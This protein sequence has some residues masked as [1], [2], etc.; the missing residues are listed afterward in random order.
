MVSRVLA[1]SRV[2]AINTP[3]LPQCRE[4]RPEK[5]VI[6]QATPGTNRAGNIA[7][8]YRL[9]PGGYEPRAPRLPLHDLFLKLGNSL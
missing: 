4:Y 8:E 9:Y 3:D 1:L 2:I 6:S 7:I 5:D